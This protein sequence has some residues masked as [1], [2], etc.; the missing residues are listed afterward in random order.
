MCINE[1]ILKK[2]IQTAYQIT[3][4]VCYLDSKYLMKQKLVF[5]WFNTEGKS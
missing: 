1:I 5:R 2:T 3:R 4:M